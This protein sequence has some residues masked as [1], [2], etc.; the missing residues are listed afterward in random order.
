MLI[1]LP[2]HCYERAIAI[3]RTINPVAPDT[4]CLKGDIGCLFMSKGDY[5]QSI[6]YFEKAIADLEGMPDSPKSE[7]ICRI[8][9]FTYNFFPQGYLLP[10]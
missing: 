6:V 7:V 3:K 4:A 1:L 9:V 2:R 10:N 5:R 8:C